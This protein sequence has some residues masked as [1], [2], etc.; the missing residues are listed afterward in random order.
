MN[1]ITN[2]LEQSSEI[3]M[4][5][6]I[7]FYNSINGVEYKSGYITNILKLKSGIFILFKINSKELLIENISIDSANIWELL[8]TNEK[9]TGIISRG[10]ILNISLHQN[11]IDK[12]FDDK[13]SN[14]MSQ[15]NDILYELMK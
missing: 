12:K 7:G 14:W 15:E 6:N 13:L 2:E 5:Y 3:G 1:C 9:P 8:F 11:K 10:T 4:K